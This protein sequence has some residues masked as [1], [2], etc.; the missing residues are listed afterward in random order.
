MTHRTLMTGDDLSPARGDRRRRRRRQRG[1]RSAVAVV[2][3]LVVVLAVIGGVVYVGSRLVGGFL[4]M[5]ADYPGAG[6]T[7]V[8]VEIKEGQSTRSIAGTLH[9]AGVIRTTGAFVNAA[10][11]NPRA[12]TIQPGFYKLK[13]EMKASIALAALLDDKNRVNKPAT[14]PEGLRLTDTLKILAK[15]SGLPLKDFQAA[16]KKPSA[17]GLPDF[18]NDR[19]EGFLFP[20]TYDVTPGTTAQDLLQQM[21]GSFTSMAEDVDLSNRAHG[22]RLSPYED[23]PK[24][25]RVLFNRLHRGMR[26]ELDST[27]TYGLGI[28]RLT[29]TAAERAKDTPYNTYLHAGLPIGPISSPGREAIEAVLAPADGNWLFFVTVNPE[30]KETKFASTF[31]EHQKNV[32]EF[33]QW[34]RNH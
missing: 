20:A 1:G 28:H 34:L 17:L 22:V 24:V 33:Q 9:D 26:L 8:R 2:L 3:A 19:P 16:V 6:T 31:E 18:A 11:G 27:V 32:Q 7:P 21:V 13:K 14:V 29:T 15:R 4:G 30:T 5:N 12:A 25:A 23:F 10:R